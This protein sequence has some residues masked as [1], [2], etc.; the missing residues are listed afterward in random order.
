MAVSPEHKNW[1]LVRTVTGFSDD[2]DHVD[3]QTAPAAAE[4]FH[5]GAQ[6]YP[7]NRGAPKPH[8]VQVFVTFIDNA[9]DILDPDAGTT[10]G[11]FD[12]EILEIVEETVDAGG[13][14]VEVIVDGTAITS[15]SGYKVYEFDGFRDSVV[16]PRLTNITQP[17]S[18][19]PTKYQVWMR[20][21]P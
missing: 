6:T 3:L 18:G 14:A 2:T 5:V 9:D 19:S 11:T 16:W 13:D 4:Q 20:S 17:S 21:I 1:T 8:G 12:L 15:C 7:V 10:R